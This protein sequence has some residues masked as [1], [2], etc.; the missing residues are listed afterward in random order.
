[1]R[2]L[3]LLVISSLLNLANAHLAYGQ[4]KTVS[5]TYLKK[6]YNGSDISCNG[7]KDAVITITAIDGSGKY[8]YSMDNG[9][10]FQDG[11]VFSGLGVGSY[12]IVVKDKEIFSY[13]PPRKTVN[14]AYSLNAVTISSGLDV[15]KHP[16]CFS[17]SDGEIRLTAYGGNGQLKYSIDNGITFQNSGNFSN[18]S[19]G[20]YKE[21][22]TDINGCNVTS[23]S[24]TLKGPAEIKVEVKNVSNASCSKP[25][26]DITLRGTGSTGDYMYSLDGQPFFWKARNEYHQFSNLAIGNHQLLVKDNYNNCVTTYNFEITNSLSA[27]LSAPENVCKEENIIL[28]VNIFGEISKSQENDKY[29]ATFQDNQMNTFT[30]TNLDFGNNV[31]TVGQLQGSITFKLI[32][33]KSNVGCAVA[34]I[35]AESTVIINPYGTWLGFTS[36]WNDPKNWPCGQLPDNTTSVYIGRT[37]NDPVIDRKAAMVHTLSI[38][39]NS[40]LKVR[41]LLQISGWIKIESGTF[42]VREGSLELNGEKTQYISGSMFKNRTIRNLI[43][44]NDAGLEVNDATGDTLNI[45][46]NLTFGSLRSVILS[47][48]NITL[49]STI[50]GTANIGVVGKENVIK[51]KFVVERYINTG[52]NKSL[53]QHGKAWV[54]LATPTIGSTIYE[55]WQESGKSTGKT[56]IQNNYKGFGTLLTTG[57]NKVP[58]NGFDVFTAPGPSIKTFNFKSGAYDQGPQSTFDPIYNEKGYLVMIRGDRSVFTSNGAANPVV[59]RTK[60][61]IITGTTKP[62]EVAG[63]KWES[64]GNPYASRIYIKNIQRTGGVDEFIT[65]WDPKLGGTYGLG[66]YQTLVNMGSGYMAIPGGGSYGK[67]PVTFIESGQAFFVQATKEDGTVFFTENSKSD[68]K[69]SNFGRGGGA[70]SKLSSLRSSLFALGSGEAVLADG[71]IL[72]TGDFSN[73]IDGNDARKMGNS[74]ENFSILSCGKLLTVESRQQITTDDTLFFNMTGMRAQSYRLQL[75]ATELGAPGMQAWLVDAFTGMRTPLNL[76]N[77]SEIE[78]TVTNQFGA[79]AANRF[80]I[81]FSP[82][83]ILPVTF[84]EVKATLSNANVLVEWTVEAESN[85]KQYEIEKSLD[86]R[87]FSIAA[88]IAAEKTNGGNYQWLDQAPASGFNYYRIR[89]VDLDGKTSLTQIVKVKTE[90]S[91]GSISVYPNPI[92]NGTVNLQLGNQP[93]G[94]YNLR[95]LNPVGQVLLTTKINHVGGNHTEKINWDHSMPRGMYTLEVSHAQAGVKIIKLMY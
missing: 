46:G 1:M 15:N 12:N 56:P 95:L 29:T 59:L 64:I 6:S 55:S 66:A 36:D 31:L 9:E 35:D 30:K 42:D 11:N 94:V 52:T 23:N 53:G 69:G 40:S 14:V 38:G 39:N 70:T 10:T 83:I 32:S 81:L 41:N 54:L 47:G 85:L 49:K 89:S 72:L 74:A 82:A 18:L 27:T 21:F 92:A 58:D 34:V 60:G 84:T 68:L 17:S 79:A 3:L 8:Q 71:N 62:I 16:K 93:E 4:I 37:A 44:S 78:F 65:L 77:T 25:S 22:I 45:T 19:P 28:I 87:L 61:E 88:T 50:D 13:S 90:N 76:N 33:I 73:D 75:I 67:E 20:T 48:D 43:I 80:M 26:G 2:I 7:K 24:V 57:F 51:G 86:G 91:V 5:F 63:G